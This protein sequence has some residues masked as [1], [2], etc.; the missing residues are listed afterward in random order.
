MRDILRWIL[1][2]LIDL[3]ARVE[4]RGMEKLPQD[5]AFVIATNHLGMLDATLLYYAID[6]WD[7]FVPVAEKWEDVAF[8]RWL[9]KHLNFVFIDRF[10]PDLKAMRQMISLMEKGHTLVIAPE[11]TRSPVGSMIEGKPGASYLAAKLQRPIV[12][13]GLAGTEDSVVFGNLRRLRRSA[14]LINAGAPFLLPPLSHQDRDA[15]LREDTDEIMCRIAALIPEKNRGI[16]AGHPRL[17]K[18]LAAD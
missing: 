10:N 14:V 4:I 12:P 3:V 11:G 9:G 18:L 15:A 7:V 2:R 5:G 8:L 13:I 1:R 16:Y 17:R 6:R